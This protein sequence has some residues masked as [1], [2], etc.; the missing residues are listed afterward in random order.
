M[1]AHM[2]PIHQLYGEQIYILYS[3]LIKYKSKTLDIKFESIHI[4]FTSFYAI[5]TKLKN[6]KQ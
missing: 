5:F 1:L 6:H 3:I 2:S 4:L